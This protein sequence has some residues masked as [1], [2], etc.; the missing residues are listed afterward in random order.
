MAAK[1]PPA[2]GPHTPPTSAADHHVTTREL[3]ISHFLERDP[4]SFASVG[5]LIYETALRPWDG[6]RLSRKARSAVSLRAVR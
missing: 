3:T 4:S 1:P 6:A 5:I 2:T